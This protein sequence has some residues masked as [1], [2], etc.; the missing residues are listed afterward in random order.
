MLEK[1]I[2]VE[3]VEVN[4][5]VGFYIDIE[6]VTISRYQEL[7]LRYLPKWFLKWWPVRYITIWRD[8]SPLSCSIVFDQGIPIKKA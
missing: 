4:V 7:R 5:S 6:E 8:A 3:V 1:V 2:E